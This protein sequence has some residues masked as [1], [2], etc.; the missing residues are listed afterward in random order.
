MLSRILLANITVAAGGIFVSAAATAGSDGDPSA[1]ASEPFPEIAAAPPTDYSGVRIAGG[2]AIGGEV[3]FNPLDPKRLAVGIVIETRCYVKASADGGRTWAELV[4]L[5]QLGDEECS[6][7]PA[8]AYAADGTR[9]YAAYS[10]SQANNM[11]MTGVAVSVSTDDG[12]TWS[13]PSNAIPA[14]EWENSHHD[15]RL[16]AAPDGPWV[17]LAATAAGYFGSVIY[18]TSSD[19]QGSSWTPHKFIPESQQRFLGFDLAAGRSGNVLIAFAY[20]YALVNPL[21]NKVQVARS[22]DHG[23]SFIYGVADQNLN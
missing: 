11:H 5:P 23:A 21:T 7:M 4:Q 16:A 2:S 1:A 9:L 6:D 20:T 14:D 15:V 19:D 22:A 18:F 8:L 17:Y 3:A 10:Y 13:T 12:A